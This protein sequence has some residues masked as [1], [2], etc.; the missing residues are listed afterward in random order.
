MKERKLPEIKPYHCGYAY[1]RA[2]VDLSKHNGY[3]E[4]S[5]NWHDYAFESWGE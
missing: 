4:S 5:S 2:V 1:F 3:D